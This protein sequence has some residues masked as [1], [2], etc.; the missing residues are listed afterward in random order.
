VV[1][2]QVDA[3]ICQALLLAAGRGDAAAFAELYDR[4]APGV[5]GLIRSVLPDADEAERVVVEV[6]RHVWW[7]ASRYDPA[8]GDAYALLMTTAWR[9]A[10]DR[11]P[12]APSRE[13]LVLTSHC[14][15]K[16]G[17]VAEL[18]GVPSATALSML[19]EELSS[20]RPDPKVVRQ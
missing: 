5:F 3:E 8:D 20:L 15:Q 13:V 14:G 12:V 1:T 16:L 9:C 10:R 6:Y 19:N 17:A 18:L 11:R 2:D 4:T 7:A